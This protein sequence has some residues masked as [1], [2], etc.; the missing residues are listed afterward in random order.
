MVATVLAATWITPGSI[1]PAILYILGIISRSPWEAVKVE[2]R[3]PLIKAP[4]RVPAAPAS[5]CISIN[6]TGAPNK[7]NLSWLK[8]SIFD[9]IG[10]DG[11]IG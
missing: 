2:A 4:W 7:F 6:F 11:V 5:L 10:L 1:S 9:A 8:E 3:D